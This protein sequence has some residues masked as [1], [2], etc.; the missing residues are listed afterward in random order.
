MVLRGACSFKGTKR[1]CTARLHSGAADAPLWQWNADG[2]LC[3]KHCGAH[4]LRP[5]SWVVLGLNKHSGK[6]QE[7]GTEWE[8]TVPE[9]WEVSKSRKT[10]CCPLHA[11][12]KKGRVMRGPEGKLKLKLKVQPLNPFL[13]RC[14]NGIVHTLIIVL[15]G[16]CIDCCVCFKG[17]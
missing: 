2:W 10:F 4:M 1:A 12:Q 8:G 15:K 9:D 6:C 16:D 17:V 3:P 7:C 11:R 13:L 14:I 5:H